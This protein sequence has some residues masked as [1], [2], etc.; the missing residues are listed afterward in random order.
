MK[1]LNRI[2]D[3]CK[4]IIEDCGIAVTVPRP[5]L[6]V[7]TRATKRWG[8]S[9][10][11]FNDGY[12]EINISKRMLDD[13]ADEYPVHN[14]MIHEMLHQMCPGDGHNGNW[15]RYAEKISTMTVYN[16]TRCTNYDDWGVK[17]PSSDETAK[18]ICKCKTC[19]VEVKRQ[20]MSDFVKHPE[21]YRHRN[22]SGSFVR[23]R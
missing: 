3:E 6:K 4:E 1:D 13:D 21:N 23:I 2:Y 15:K 19:G 11:H 7:N 18:Y 16:I 12:R 8:Q 10:I 17:L 9:R 5:T 14:T 22:C 20:K